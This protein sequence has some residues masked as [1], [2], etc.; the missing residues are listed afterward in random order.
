MA[1]PCATDVPRTLASGLREA[2]T[3]LPVPTLVGPRQSGK[4]TLARSTFLTHRYVNLERP[5][6]RDT[7]LA[8]PR[9][10][11]ASGREGILLDEVQ[12]VPGPL[13]WIQAEVDEDPRPG[14]FV[15]TGSNQLARS[16]GVAQTLAGRTSRHTLLPPDLAELR[17]FGRPLAL[18][19]MLRE[20][21][22]PRIHDVGIP[23]DR[24]LADY[25]ATDVERDV[26]QV[27]NVGDLTTFRTFFRLLA[28]R[29]A[30]ELNLSALGADAGV[31]QPTARAWLSALESGFLVLRL[32]PWFR[33]TRKQ[34][35]RSPKVH[36][37]DTG[38]AAWLLG[39]RSADE[40]VTHPLRG[41]LFETWVVT[42]LWKQR[43]HGGRVPG[44]HHWRETRG[45]EVDVVVDDG[46]VLWL[47]E[48]KS[49]TTVAADWFR[50]LT[51]AAEQ[52]RADH[53]EKEVRPVI[54]Y[55]GDEAT[56]RLGVAVVPWSAV[57]ELGLVASG[58][59][60][61]ASRPTVS[62]SPRGV[63]PFIQLVDRESHLHRRED[64]RVPRAVHGE[65]PTSFA[66]PAVHLHAGRL[67]V[68]QHVPQQRRQGAV[69]RELPTPV[70]GLRG[71][72]EH[73]DDQGG[74]DAGAVGLRVAL[75][76]AAHHGGVRVGPRAGGGDPHREVRPIHPAGPAAEAGVQDRDDVR[77]HER[78]LGGAAGHRD[79]LAVEELVPDPGPLHEVDVLG[80]AQ[81]L[82][83]RLGHW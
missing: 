17:A 80:V 67:R 1:R 77:L 50:G 20:G 64:D 26:R 35:V 74:V 29:T 31:S 81:A 22:F 38:L 3:Q 59:G 27:L 40:L 10:I 53:P 83:G 65:L 33:N 66:E 68:R 28:G 21:A 18:W 56:T 9:A 75:Q 24:W 43:V 34:L 7:A 19:P 70:P 48:A 76:R 4:S 8:D 36:L 11:L 42:E 71:G 57:G 5:D 23:A 60:V 52:A 51:A 61:D 14:R 13:S 49:G 63:H 44:I 12:R 6:H 45:A 39:V 79:H 78:V 58:T 41:A 37:V 54:V 25:V 16:A 62:T 69:E 73:L 82:G 30:Q 15:L 55:G 32:P 72:G 2:A 47:V 46:P